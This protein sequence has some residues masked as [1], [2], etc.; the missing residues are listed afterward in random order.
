MILDCQYHT[1]KKEH[2]Q[3]SNLRE[4]KAKKQG[5]FRRA[6]RKRRPRLGGRY[7]LHCMRGIEWA[8][9]EPNSFDRRGIL[10]TVC[11]YC[12]CPDIDLWEDNDD[13]VCYECDAH[14]GCWCCSIQCYNNLI[15]RNTHKLPVFDAKCYP[16]YIGYVRDRIKGYNDDILNIYQ[17]NYEL[18]LQLLIFGYLKVDTNMILD[19]I[20][21]IILMY[22]NTKITSF[23]PSLLENQY[24]SLETN[25]NIILQ[26][27]E[28]KS[29]NCTYYTATYSN[30]ILRKDKDINHIYYTLIKCL[31]TELN[32]FY[33]G[34]IPNK[35]GTPHILKHSVTNIPNCYVY[36]NNGNCYYNNISNVSPKYGAW[37]MKRRYRAQDVIK[38]IIDF[39]IGVISFNIIN[40]CYN[41]EPVAFRFNKDIEYRLIVA[42]CHNG[43]KY[44]LIL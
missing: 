8:R 28:E 4:V 13:R 17:S 23:H 41:R 42:T 38:C 15:S 29:G 9:F 7:Y 39:K 12:H 10:N 26:T 22:Y 16:Y 44:Q 37:I 31:E 20:L 11:V 40:T 25:S 27:K 5:Q 6:K 3:S 19:D 32:G 1:I 43:D 14:D 33:I 18:N 30:I 21:N 35:Y 36:G 2:I 24:L 34:I